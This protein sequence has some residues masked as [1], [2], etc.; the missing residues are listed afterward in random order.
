MMGRKNTNKVFFI[1]AFKVLYFFYYLVDNANNAD[2]KIK[3]RNFFYLFI[4]SD[5]KKMIE[6]LFVSL[7]SIIEIKRGYV[8]CKMNKNCSKLR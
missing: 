1:E 6:M 2:D 5:K 8:F 3:K 7:V 4:S